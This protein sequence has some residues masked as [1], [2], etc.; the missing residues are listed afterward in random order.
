[1]TTLSQ[2]YTLLLQTQQHPEN[3]GGGVIMALISISLIF[4]LSMSGKV[5]MGFQVPGFP[6][7]LR[8]SRKRI[9]S[10]YFAYYNRLAP[11]KKRKFEQK[12]QEFIHRKEFIP[13]NIPT[14][15][16]E[17][18]VLIAACAIQLTFGLPKIFLTHFKRIIVYPDD[19]YSIINK[20]YHKGEVNP[21][22]HAIVLSWRHFLEGYV[23]PTD[24]YNLGLHEMTHALHLENRIAN[25]EFG[26]FHPEVLSRWQILSHAEMEKI[27]SGEKHFLRAYA[28]ANREE[29]LAV[30]VENFFEKSEEFRHQL[31]EVYG[32]LSLLL[33]QN[34]L[35][36]KA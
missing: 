1:M 13:R 26:F 3:I 14:V 4:L 31:P 12:V 29:F 34:P 6:T 16:E 19:Y 28:G 33:N 10:E 24:G 30:A 18:R 32:T 8:R 22:V 23:S 21:R 35:N 15:T 27:N 7:P 5:Q 36:N 25:K 11:H 20:T 9:L 17:M 2:H